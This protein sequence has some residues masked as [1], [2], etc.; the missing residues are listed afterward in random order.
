MTCG[1]QVSYVGATP[2]DAG[3]SSTTQYDL[4]L[5]RAAGPIA[6]LTFYVL[7]HQVFSFKI[8]G[9]RIS[10]RDRTTGRKSNKLS[11]ARSWRV[12]K[13]ATT[14]YISRKSSYSAVYS[15]CCTTLEIS[16]VCYPGPRPYST[17]K[18]LMRSTRASDVETLFYYSISSP[19]QCS[20]R[21]ERARLNSHH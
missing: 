20:C 8:R 18:N 11:V 10:E 4:N 5:V 13:W 2:S 1:L 15:P 9:L 19:D 3:T 14:K 16:H 6:R 7:L 21:E 12:Q 17:R